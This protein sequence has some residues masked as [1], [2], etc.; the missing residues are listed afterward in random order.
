MKR[1]E[2]W[3]AHVDKRRPVVL[4]SREE[5]YSVRSNIVVAPA[6]TN[7]RGF[8]VELK[9]GRAE[10]LERPCVVNCDWIVTVPIEDLVERVGKLSREKLARLD[11]T[12]RFALGL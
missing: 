6:S 3:W 12:L 8:S 1:G 9:L 2:V 7:V 5:A 10:G 11:D 4:I